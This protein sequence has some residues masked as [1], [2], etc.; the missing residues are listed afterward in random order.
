MTGAELLD[1]VVEDV[2]AERPTSPIRKQPPEVH[3]AALEELSRRYRVALE[4]PGGDAEE[5]ERLRS[6]TIARLSELAVAHE[7]T[8][9]QRFNRVAR[10]EAVAE[11]RAVVDLVDPETLPGSTSLLSL[12]TLLGQISR[13][14]EACRMAGIG[15]LGELQAALRGES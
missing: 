3:E 1:C 12:I 9:G 8:L 11:F 14:L 4:S 6:L 7:A 10:A 5:A 2:I 15:T 13:Q